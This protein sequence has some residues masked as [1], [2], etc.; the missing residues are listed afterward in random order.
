MPASDEF[1]AKPRA[2]FFHTALFVRRS[3]CARLSFSSI[4]PYRT[5]FLPRFPSILSKEPTRQ[6]PRFSSH[7]APQPGYPHRLPHR[8][9]PPLLATNHNP[10]TTASVAKLV[11]SL[12]PTT[13]A[14]LIAYVTHLAIADTFPK[15]C[16]RE[17]RE[18][19]TNLRL[20]SYRATNSVFQLLPFTALQRA[21]LSITY[22]LFP[23]TCP[24]G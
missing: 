7:S 15:L 21:P 19:K 6:T 17:N 13:M 10:L 23:M 20:Q 2:F 14:K 12:G 24:Q 3:R 16:W 18:G 1:L 4:Q 11:A 22:N 9:N 8:A 5:T